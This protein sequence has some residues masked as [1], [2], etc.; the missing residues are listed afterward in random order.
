MSFLSPWRLLLLVAPAALLVGYLL[1]QRRRRSLALRFSSVD[2]LASVLPKRAGWQRHAVAGTLIAAIT[3]LVVGFAQPAATVRTPKSRATIL[4]AFDVSGSMAAT[5]VTPTRLAAAES[6]GRSFVQSL[7][8]ALQVG[9]VTFDSSARVVLPP[10][11]DRS[12][13]LAALAALSVGGGTATGDAITLSLNAATTLP[14]G[15]DGKPAPATIVLLSDGTP[16]VGSGDQSPAESADSAA[17][18]AKAAG[19]PVNTI[20]FGTQD[21]TV[22]VDGRTIPVPSDPAAMA[23]I[24]TESGGASFTARNVGQLKSV[25]ARIGRVIGYDVHRREITAAFTGAGLAIALLAAVAGLVWLQ[26]IV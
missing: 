18:K 8:K 15:A 13:V 17:A 16:T 21:G 3:V 14:P 22:S 7:P 11:S 23:R 25:Y 10:T 4:L 6:A 12:S 24:A 1:A 2:L 26:R 20:A 5:D 9:L 19:V